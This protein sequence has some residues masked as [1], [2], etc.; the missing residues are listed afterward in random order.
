MKIFGAVTTTIAASLLAACASAPKP[1][2]VVLVDWTNRACESPAYSDILG[3]YV[4]QI[5]YRD[6]EAR[7]CRWNTEIA[8]IGVS[9]VSDCSLTGTI[10]ATPDVSGSAG[11]L[12]SDV[13]LQAGFVVGLSDPDLNRSGPSSVIIHL[14]EELPVTTSNGDSIVYPIAQYDSLT[15]EYGTL[16]KDAGNILSRQ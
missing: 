6:S 14:P 15:A 13:Q 8:I 16:I 2:P 5:N 7:A 3:N 11:Y 4:G 1:E 9:M 12:C 10:T